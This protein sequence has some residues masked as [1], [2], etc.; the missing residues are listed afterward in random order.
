M[1]SKH[2]TKRKIQFTIEV[3]TENHKQAFVNGLVKHLNKVLS[4]KGTVYA[5]NTS[6]KEDPSE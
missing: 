4:R 6:I 3:S 2:N 1:K 5:I